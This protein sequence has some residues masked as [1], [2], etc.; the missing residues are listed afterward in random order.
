MI[1][2]QLVSSIGLN[3][4][5]VVFVTLFTCVHQIIY[6]WFVKRTTLIVVV[7]YSSPLFIIIRAGV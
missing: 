5:H 7:L 4:F 3:D 1:N 2:C 6:M